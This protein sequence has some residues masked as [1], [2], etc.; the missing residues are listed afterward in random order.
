MTN[1]DLLKCCFVQIFFF[2]HNRGKKMKSFKCV[3]F[4]FHHFAVVLY[5]APMPHY[6][7]YWTGVRFDKEPLTMSRLF[8][9]GLVRDS[10]PSVGLS[11]CRSV[12]GYISGLPGATCVAVTAFSISSFLAMLYTSTSGWRLQFEICSWIQWNRL[13]RCWFPRF[14]RMTILWT[15]LK[16]VADNKSRQWIFGNLTS[17]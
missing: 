5:A 3:M 4:N 15:K 7:R 6:H 10:N 14:V 11:V 16:T 17:L 1:R 2:Y 8:C 9:K 13:P 12:H